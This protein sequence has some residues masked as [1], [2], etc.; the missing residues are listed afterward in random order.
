MLCSEFKNTNEFKISDYFLSRQLDE[1]TIEELAY[2]H[3]NRIPGSTIVKDARI[4]SSLYDL[5]ETAQ[6]SANNSRTRIYGPML[7]CFAILDQIGGLYRCKLKKSKYENN[8]KAS[9]NGLKI[10]LHLFGKYEEHEIE[11]LA[12]LRN[13]L[14]HDGSLLS[15]SWDRKTN[16]IFRIDRST[17]DS[18]TL[19]SPRKTWDGDY[20]D[21]LND[22]L[23]IINVI[24][25]KRDVEQIV[26]NCTKQLLD[27]NLII[28]ITDPREFFYKFLFRTERANCAD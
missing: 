20:H 3:L 18:K 12:T 6:A 17:E 4:S 14:Y 19:T 21:C 24:S 27:D 25:L 28:M 15:K 26:K 8:N 7:A 22:Y 13:G 1:L 23:S 9:E 10:A 2:I 16:V 11:S 5:I